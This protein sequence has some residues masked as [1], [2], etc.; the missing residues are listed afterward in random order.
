MVIRT[1][2][3]FVIVVVECQ[4]KSVQQDDD[5]DEVLKE[6]NKND[7]K[8]ILNYLLR[9]HNYDNELSQKGVFTEEK[10]RPFVIL[11]DVLVVNET[12]TNFDHGLGLQVDI[13][14]WLF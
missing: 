2:L 7:E 11:W 6:S 3:I 4:S 10:K 12:T 1:V 13:N 9:V 14:T 8:V 5:H